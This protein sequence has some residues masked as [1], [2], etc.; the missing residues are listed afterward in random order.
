MVIPL[1]GLQRTETFSD[2]LSDCQPFCGML[3]LGATHLKGLNG[4]QLSCDSL[5]PLLHH[6]CLGVTLPPQ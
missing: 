4:I 1:L 6:H 3:D 5:G 2:Y